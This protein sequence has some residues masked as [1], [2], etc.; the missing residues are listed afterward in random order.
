MEETTIINNITTGIISGLVTS[1]LFLLILSGFRPKIKISPY[2]AKE[3]DKDGVFY[4]FKV[5]NLSKRSCINIKVDASVAYTEKVE[6]GITHWTKELKLNQTNVFEISGYRKKDKNADYAWRFTTDDNLTKKWKG[7]PDTVR[8]RII[9]T[10]P[11]TGLSKA[12]LHEYNSKILA[13]KEGSHN[14]GMDL[15]VSKYFNNLSKRDMLK[16]ASVGVRRHLD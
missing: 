9:A 1:F 14:F 4:T 3:F 11:T 5:V 2:I 7:Y 13:L 16:L 15:H 10:D 6:G 8:F 12:F